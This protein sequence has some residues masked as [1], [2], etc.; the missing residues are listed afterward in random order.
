MGKNHRFRHLYYLL[1]LLSLVIALLLP[2]SY[3]NPLSLHASPPAALALAPNQADEAG[4]TAYETGQFREAVV[5]FE[6][7]I[8]HYASQNDSLRQ[9]MMWGNL[10]LAQQQL[11]NWEGANGAIATSLELLEGLA[12]ESRSV[13]DYHSIQAQVLT[14]AG[15]LH[16]EQGQAEAALERWQQAEALYE[17]LD[18]NPGRWQ[19]QIYQA[20]ALQ[21]LG[22]YQRAIEVLERVNQSLQN[23]PDSAIKVGGL[24]ELGD[25]LYTAGEL[26][27]S[28]QVLEQGVA[29]AHR[30]NLP[31][32]VV[33]LS[34]NLANTLQGLGETEAALSLYQGVTTAPGIN[35][36]QAQLN[37]LHLLIQ[38]ESWEAAEKVALQ[39]DAPLRA[40]PPGRTNLYIRIQYVET[41]RGLLH[42]APHLSGTISSRTLGEGLSIA[43]HQAQALGDRHTESYA[44]GSLGR[45]YEEAGQYREA[46]TVTQQ[47]LT[48]AQNTRAD[49]LTY[50]W[51][52][53]MGRLLQAQRRR[54]EAIA[55][56]QRA[57]ATLQTIR[58]DLA[59]INPEV[60]FTFQQT[61][62]PIHR[63]LVSLLLQGDA[64]GQPTVQELEAVRQVIESLQQAELENFFREA[65]LDAQPI[66]IDQID[67]QAAIL[68]PIL[69]PD[70]LEVIVRLP[71]RP[72][73]HHTVAV[74]PDEVAQTASQLR[75]RLLNRIAGDALV[76]PSA[77]QL[78][79]WLISPIATDLQESGVR[80]LV[81]VLDGPLRNLPMAVLHDGDRFL[82]EQYSLALTPGLNLLAPRPLDSQQ[83]SVIAAGLTEGRQGFSP[84]PGVNDEL[85][86]I[87]QNL[88]SQVL[89]NQGFTPDSLQ[90]AIATNSAP[91][92][93]LATHGQ[94][95]SNLE[96]TF[97]LS[98]S[99]RIS[100]NQLRTLLQGTDLNR[101]NPV[102]LLVMS[103]CQT[104]S[105][106]QRALL[107]LAG[108]AVQAGARST[109]ASL[110]SV[111][112]QA[113]SEL[114]AH[115]YSELA[116]EG[117]TKA[118]ALRH[119]QVAML[120][121]PD[122]GQ[123]PYYWAAFVLLGNWL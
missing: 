37:L 40:L 71:D 44:L 61:I 31:E 49:D 63:E 2:L 86:S 4:R 28:R 50:R 55:A 16:L 6:Q 3:P 53:Q 33:D 107:G 58:A 87:K 113:T 18:D 67:N 75:R 74:T 52:W 84:L 68:Y 11:G 104:A 51:H 26:A 66:A 47:A 22:F 38:Q 102:E 32:Q 119:A 122:Y 64:S 105:G 59:A 117:I 109:L 45:L 56:Y 12:P 89:L 111:D 10:A 39:L 57:I 27:R 70:R 13:T 29:I 121:N 80:T 82:V 92:V 81:F 103:A 90:R 93:H 48:L 25:A 23:V 83:L 110:W 112:D 78:Y 118:E 76:L 96:D 108:I 98:W 85:E 100:I 43:I 34:L 115:F 30:L 8:A 9:A 42:H 36:L 94:F 99:D 123:W 24:Q 60:Q 79:D 21:G 1:G 91:I 62:E 7:A 5:L 54:E 20:R 114:M 41:L 46:E 106:D 73:Q 88:P 14:L 35:G 97:I 120:Q 65:C 15:Q 77:Q 101:Q 19:S 72:L 17:A 69:L 116:Q 95:S